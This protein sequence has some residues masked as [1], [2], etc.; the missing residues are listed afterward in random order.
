[1]QTARPTL[2]EL[3][4]SKVFVASLIWLITFGA[5]YA[6]GAGGPM[7]VGIATALAIVYLLSFRE[8]QAPKDTNRCAPFR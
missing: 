7:R 1:M 5:T 2:V 4:D 6:G 8:K 3:V